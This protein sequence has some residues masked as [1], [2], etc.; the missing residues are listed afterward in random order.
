M[1]PR[2]PAGAITVDATIA[3]A[4]APRLLSALVVAL[5]IGLTRQTLWGLVAGSAVYLGLLQWA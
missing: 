4:T 2:W 1:M 3:A 5:V